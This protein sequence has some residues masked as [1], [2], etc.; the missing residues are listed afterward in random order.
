MDQF[1]CYN[2]I[3]HEITNLYIPE[4]NEITEWAIV[5]FFEMIYCMLYSAGVDLRY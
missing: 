1:C 5:I 3:I 2:G 4:Q